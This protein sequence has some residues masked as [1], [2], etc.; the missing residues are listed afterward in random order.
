[1]NVPMHVLK[2]VPTLRV[3]IHVTVFPGTPAA[4]AI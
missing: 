1:M 4:T 3:A 2:A